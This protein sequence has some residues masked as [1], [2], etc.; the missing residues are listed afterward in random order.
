MLKADAYGHGIEAVAK[1]LENDVFAF[2]VATLEEGLTLRRLGIKNDVL[3]LACAVDEIE[4]A[5]QA[6]LTIGISHCQQIAKLCQ[7]A[8]DK[9]IDARRAKLHLAI[10]TGMHRLGFE[11]DELNCLLT[12]LH[13][14]GFVVGGVYS[15]LRGE[16][17]TQLDKFDEVCKLVREIYP[18]ALRH[19]ASSHTYQIKRF[20]FDMVRVGL[21]AYKG[22]MRVESSVIATRRVNAGEIVS[23][24]NRVLKNATNVAVVF[25]GYADGIARENASS[26]YLNNKKCSTIGDVCMD[27]TI[28]DTG[29]MLAKIG[30]TAVIFDSEYAEQIEKERNTIL[31]TIYTS[32][33]GRIQREYLY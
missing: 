22:A 18:N 24:G 1:S 5:L 12:R 25:G 3:L 10:D 19:I 9:R 17:D 2:G 26:I 13:Q 8:R 32:F 33:K 11:C 31:Y 15:H 21:E 7:L 30:D 14:N 23:Y 20:E 16:S 29:D 4:M 27:M 28:V 6:D